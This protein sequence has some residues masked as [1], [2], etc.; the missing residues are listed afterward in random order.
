MDPNELREKLGV[1]Y[2]ADGETREMSPIERL[3]AIL[4]AGCRAVQ[5][6]MKAPY[7]PREILPIARDFS[8][9][10]RQYDALFFV[11]DSL[12]MA[13]ASGAAGVHLGQGDFCIAKARLLV[14][15]SF[16]IGASA[17]TG[18]L[19]RIAEE[20]GADYIGSG[21]AFATRTKHDASVIGPE[22]I[23][24]VVNGSSLP[25]VAI[26]GITEQNIPLLDGIGVAGVAVGHALTHAADPHDAA[27]KMFAALSQRQC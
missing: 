6:R 2:I 17:K 4:H 12:E 26:G 13:L 3:E 8:S 5:L 25:C 24:H 19:A 10:C 9:L 21:A 7:T 27:G 23:R 15:P 14:P 22:G 1:Y 20:W 11:N 16:I 18:A